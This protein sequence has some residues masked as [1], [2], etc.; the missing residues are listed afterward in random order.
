MLPVSQQGRELR[1]NGFKQNDG[2]ATAGR[3]AREPESYRLIGLLLP[4]MQQGWRRTKSGTHEVNPLFTGPPLSLLQQLLAK[5]LALPVGMYGDAHDAAIAK[6][7]RLAITRVS[8]QG[9]RQQL[10]SGA[11]AP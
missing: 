4:K 1:I 2:V 7:A 6:S 9:L 10:P 5:P 3:I 8:E 11:A